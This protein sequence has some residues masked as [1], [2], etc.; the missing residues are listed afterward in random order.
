MC[1]ALGQR[2][3]RRRRRRRRP[4]RRPGR[5]CDDIGLMVFTSG[6]TGRPKAAMMSWRGLGTA[7]ARLEH[8]ARAA[9][10][11]DSLVS[12]LPLLPCRRADV[13][14][15][16][17][18]RHRRASSTSPKACAPCRKTCA[19]WRRRS[20]SACRASGRSSTPRSRPRCARPAACGFALYQRAM[21]ALE[22]DAG[23]PR[24]EL[25]RAATPALGVLVRADPARAAQLRRPAALPRGDL[26]RRTDRTRDPAR[27]SASSACRSARPTA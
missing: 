15:P 11:G 13:L 8:R 26:G 17:P 5:R 10:S 12:Y 14:D 19:S 9:P 2:F 25:G 21:V 1:V 24:V 3:E 6:S 23:K 4:P 27:S 18:G 22:G 7:A 20:S 16:H